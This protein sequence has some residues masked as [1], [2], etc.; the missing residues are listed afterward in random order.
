VSPAVTP[1]LDSLEA[2][3]GGRDDLSA[4]HTLARARVCVCVCVCV[5]VWALRR[6]MH[7]RCHGKECKW[8]E[9]AVVICTHCRH[10]ASLMHPPSS[11]RVPL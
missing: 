3:K 8:G 5:C 4:P 9:A 1:A 7:P 2:R 11:E 6:G 10:L